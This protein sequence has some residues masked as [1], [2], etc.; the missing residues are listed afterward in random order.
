M[1]APGAMW[2]RDWTW[3]LQGHWTW[4]PDMSATVT[5]E[6]VASFSAL[7]HLIYEIDIIT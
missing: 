4:I 5:I 2:E 3:E 1:L 7:G 6:L